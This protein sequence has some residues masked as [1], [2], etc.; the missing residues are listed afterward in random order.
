[1]YD[2]YTKLLLLQLHEP[3]LSLV[4]FGHHEPISAGRVQGPS[5]QLVLPH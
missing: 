2:K 4:R 3:G 1:M 5:K